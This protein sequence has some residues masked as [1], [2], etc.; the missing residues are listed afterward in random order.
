VGDRAIREPRAVVEYGDIEV[1]LRVKIDNPAEPVVFYEVIPPRVDIEGELEDRLAL[2]REVAG[3]VDAINI[4]E[5]REEKRN[6]PRKG[7]LHERIEPR[8]F[9][10]AIAN[11]TKVETVVNRVTVHDSPAEQR[12]WLRLDPR[13]RR[14]C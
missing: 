13:R 9:A 12:R 4:P 14:R 7:V 11:A 6:G 8:V 2:V 3:Q 5:I 10:E 1:T